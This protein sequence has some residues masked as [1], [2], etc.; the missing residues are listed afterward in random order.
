[1][2]LINFPLYKADL[3]HSCFYLLPDYICRMILKFNNFG[4]IF[5]NFRANKCPN[6]CP[7]E[8]LDPMFLLRAN[9]FIFVFDLLLTITFL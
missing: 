2:G 9:C 8:F 3:L 1:M 5:E 7:R 4:I 6:D